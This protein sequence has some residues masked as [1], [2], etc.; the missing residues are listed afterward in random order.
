MFQVANDSF[1]VSK[2][3]YVEDS[4]HLHS[5]VTFVQLLRTVSCLLVVLL[6]WS[7]VEE[8]MWLNKS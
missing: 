8:L 6:T 2:M 1:K 3:I 5:P 7:A 4:E